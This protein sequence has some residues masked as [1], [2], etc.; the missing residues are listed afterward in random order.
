[1]KNICVI[2]ASSRLGSSLM[3]HPNTIECTWRFEDKAEELDEWLAQHN[4]VDT[5]WH[6]ARTCRTTGIRRDAD[7]FSLDH[8]GLL[9]IL[10]TRAKDCRLVYASSKIVYGLGG[11]SNNRNEVLSADEVAQYFSDDL[12]G[13]IN[14]PNWQNTSDLDISK[15]TPA[16]NLLTNKR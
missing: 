6:V 9:K 11:D 12:I 15:L 10:S 13:T 8:G 16:Q 2:G 3:K 5:V 14:C 4:E 1:M 7:T